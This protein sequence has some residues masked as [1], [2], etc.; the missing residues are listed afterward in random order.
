VIQRPQRSGLGC[1]VAALV[2]DQAS[3]ALA[4]AFATPLSVGV[5]ILP[6]FNLVLVFNRGASFGSFSA[7]PWW[8]LSLAGLAVIAVLAT[9][10]WRTLNRWV[11]AGLGLVIGGAL[12]NVLDR[13]RQGAVTDFLDFHWGAYHWPAFNLADVAI[14][15]GV[16]LFLI[17]E[18]RR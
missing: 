15:G 16:L 7:V 13:V 18:R 2:F 10:L 8:A 14:V 4:L 17:G 9:W 1:A 3:K 6:V 5:E 12:G 11:G